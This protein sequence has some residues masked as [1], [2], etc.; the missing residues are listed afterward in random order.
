M[1]ILYILGRFQQEY[2]ECVIKKNMYYCVAVPKKG[3]GK[4]QIFECSVF[5]N[6]NKYKFKI[7]YGGKRPDIGI[8]YLL[9]INRDSFKKI[10]YYSLV[11]LSLT[12]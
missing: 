2:E 5:L 10:M 9:V 4:N 1:L 11:V 12:V 8:R 7:G 3:Y 6:N